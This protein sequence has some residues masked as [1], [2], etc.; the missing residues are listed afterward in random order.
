MAAGCS[1]EI[2]EILEEFTNRKWKNSPFNTCTCIDAEI[3]A[4]GTQV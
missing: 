4:V 1:P 3:A 2:I